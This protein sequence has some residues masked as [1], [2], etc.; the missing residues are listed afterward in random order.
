V[1]GS[2]TCEAASKRGLIVKEIVIYNCICIIDICN[3]FVLFCE[4]S[5]S[6]HWSALICDSLLF[7][8]NKDLFSAGAADRLR[9]SPR[10]IQM[11][12]LDSVARAVA[13][14]CRL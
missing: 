14:E 4:R 12:R 7:Y 2:R 3:C 8:R 10:S 13:R 11:I 9:L 1:E 5:L 6:A